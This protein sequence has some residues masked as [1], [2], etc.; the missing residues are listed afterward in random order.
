MSIPPANPLLNP[1]TF[2]EKSKGGV[3]QVR[4]QPRCVWQGR[5]VRSQSLNPGPCVDLHSQSFPV[6]RGGGADLHWPWLWNLPP[7]AA[8]SPA[9]SVRVERAQLASF[10]SF[11]TTEAVCATSGPHRWGCV[12]PGGSERPSESQARRGHDPGARCTARHSSQ[13]LGFYPFQS[14]GGYVGGSVRVCECEWAL[15]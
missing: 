1:F 8:C 3:S 10:S 5:P 14:P 15:S 13:V 2:Q 7:R 12:S 11:P 9:L 4:L 6:P